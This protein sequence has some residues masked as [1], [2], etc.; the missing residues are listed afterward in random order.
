MNSQKGYNLELQIIYSFLF[1]DMLSCILK[2]VKDH[3][4]D[5]IT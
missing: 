5:V 2:E 4:I 3:W 1:G